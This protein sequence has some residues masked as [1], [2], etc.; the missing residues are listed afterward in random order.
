MKV[1]R[2]REKSNKRCSIVSIPVRRQRDVT[3]KREREV[4]RYM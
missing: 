2:E 1:K 4:D 3:V